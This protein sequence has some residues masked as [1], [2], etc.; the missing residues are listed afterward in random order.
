[1]AVDAAGTLHVLFGSETPYAT[2]ASGGWTFERFAPGTAGG[3][4]GELALDGAGTPHAAFGTATGDFSYLL[5][6]ARR[7]ADGW[8]VEQVEPWRLGTLDGVSIAVDAAGDVHIGYV[9]DSGIGYATTRGGTD[10]DGVDQDCD[11]VDG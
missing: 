1:M 6:H 4:G 11:G 3:S 8:V 7:T 10:S 5:Q 9:R 2:N